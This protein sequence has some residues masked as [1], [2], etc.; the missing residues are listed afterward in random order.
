LKIF[1]LKIN[2]LKNRNFFGFDTVWHFLARVT[3]ILGVGTI[4]KDRSAATKWMVRNGIPTTVVKSDGRNTKAIS[5]SDLPSE[6]RLAFL[7]RQIEALHSDPGIF[8]DAAHK[9]FMQAVPSR[10]DRAERKAAI[11]RLLVSLGPGVKWDARLRLVHEQFGSDGA[12]KPRLKALL[13][14]VKGVDPIN[15]A[16]ALLDSDKGKTA[17][18]EVTPK[19][20]SFFMTTLRKAAPEFPLIQPWR[21]TRDVG[22]RPGW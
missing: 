18:F 7:K 8:G 17:S 14:A 22:K 20:W 19:A 5:I 13:T 10:R 12:S 15:Y 4:P 3:S 9:E 6:G 2:G 16:P 11:A 1:L 21:D